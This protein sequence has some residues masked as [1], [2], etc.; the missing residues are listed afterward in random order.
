MQGKDALVIVDVQNDFCPGGALAVEGADEVVPV[1]NEYI[2][3][4]AAVGL[5]IFVT[6]DWHPRK[7]SHFKTYGG[8]WP[9]H[10]VQD[11]V[12]A[13]FHRDLKLSPDM[14]VVSKGSAA[15]EDSYSAFQ[16]RDDAGVPVAELLRRLNVGRIFVGGLATD[17][18]VKYTA[19]DALQAGF[20]VVLLLDAIRGVDLQPG[21]SARALAEVRAA[22]AMS[23]SAVDELPI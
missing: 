10:C 1:L 20:A 23:L 8:V 13:E 12:G 3:H 22:G 11:T 17:Y 15:D 5:P 7:T 14:I 2:E 9:A 21:D 4:F 18:C 16:A 6:R 19:L